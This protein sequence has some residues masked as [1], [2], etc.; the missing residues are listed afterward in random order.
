MRRTLFPDRRVARARGC[1]EMVDKT[2]AASAF[3]ASAV[4]ALLIALGLLGLGCTGDDGGDGADSDPNVSLFLWDEVAGKP[5]GPRPHFSFFVTT[6]RGLFGLPAGTH[7][8]APDPVNG[9]GGDLGGIQG[10]DEICSMLAQRANAGDTKLWR[11]FL[12]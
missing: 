12:S 2:V 4:G 3:T 9:F 7:S 11:A 1:P 10:A 8:P 6:Q 5:R